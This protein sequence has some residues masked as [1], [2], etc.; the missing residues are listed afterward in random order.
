MAATT[1]ATYHGSPI[2]DG[3]ATIRA[4]RSRIKIRNL[5]EPNTPTNLP[6]R[7]SEYF[8][9]Q[10]AS[11]KNFLDSS[12]G[13]QYISNESAGINLGHKPTSLSFSEP[14]YAKIT[15]P[16][17]KRNSPVK[18]LNIKNERNNCDTAVFIPRRRLRSL[19]LPVDQE[20]W[21]REK[22]WKRSK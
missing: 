1:S 14:I 7:H 10:R 19:E 4:P 20:L 15:P 17:S 5:V 3:F 9:L 16:N 6:Q 2:H 11:T 21:L 18:H 12:C 22:K 13:V 8:T